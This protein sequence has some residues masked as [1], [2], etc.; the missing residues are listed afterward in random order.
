MA[1]QNLKQSYSYSMVSQ[2]SRIQFGAAIVLISIIPLLTLVYSLRS[3]TEGG[4]AWSGMPWALGSLACMTMML[5]YGLLMKYPRTIIRLRRQMEQIARGELPD[6]IELADDE[7]DISAIEDFFNLIID[8][9]R[10]RMVMIQKQGEKLVK[11][12][13]QRVMTESI[14]TACHCLGQ[15]ATTIA[16]YLDMLKSEVLSELGRESL[17]GC[18]RESDRMREILEELQGIEGYHTEAY[19]DSLGSDGEPAPQIITTRIDK[20]RI[21]AKREASAERGPGIAVTVAV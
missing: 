15:P 16:C 1:T 12:E 4:F 13:R 19:C 18:I 21:G 9:M 20:A 8:G 11:A 7:K 3:Q 5:G 10:E 2:G 14:C 17:S 6:T